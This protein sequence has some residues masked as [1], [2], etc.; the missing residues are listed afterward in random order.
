MVWR[1]RDGFSNVIVSVACENTK[2]GPMVVVTG[3]RG[4]EQFP[5][6]AKVDLW[7]LFE[8][9]LILEK[10]PE[11]LGIFLPGF[12]GGSTPPMQDAAG[13]VPVWRGPKRVN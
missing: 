13:I 8:E 10:A 6:D 2:S 3:R 7:H 4:V 9:P 11:D 5:R 12:I 1:F